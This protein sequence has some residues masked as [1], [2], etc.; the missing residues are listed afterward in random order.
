LMWRYDTAFM[1]NVPNK[2]AFADIAEDLAGRPTKSWL[3]P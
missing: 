2:Q 3:R 1:N